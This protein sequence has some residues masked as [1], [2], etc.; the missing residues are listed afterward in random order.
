M[1]IVLLASVHAAFVT[2]SPIL[3]SKQLATVI[4]EHY[5]PGDVMVVDG[6]YESASTLNFY[7]GIPLRILHEPSANLW[8]GS[9]FPDAPR[10]FETETSFQA[11]WN[12]PTRVFFGTDQTEPKELEGEK[13]YEIGHSGGKSILTNRPLDR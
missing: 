6:E 2:F 5:R 9:Q 7:T 11:L 10:V 3:S 4:Q 1:M 13:W 12:S 8:Y